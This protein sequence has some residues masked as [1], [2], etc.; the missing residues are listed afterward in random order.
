MVSAL[1]DNLGEVHVYTGAKD[2]VFSEGEPSLTFE[3]FEGQRKRLTWDRLLVAQAANRFMQLIEPPTSMAQRTH[4][5]MM[6]HA[7]VNLQIQTL[8]VPESHYWTVLDPPSQDLPRPFRVT[9]YSA[10]AGPAEPSRFTVEFMNT[11]MEDAALERSALEHLKDLGI[12]GREV[13][14]TFRAVERTPAG[15]PRPTI[16]NMDVIRSQGVVLDECLPPLT[17]FIGTG[18]DPSRLF[19]SE[20]FEAVWRSFLRSLGAGDE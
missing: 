2:M 12:V 14:P 7:F 5:E 4:V 17:T 18:A 15:F 9:N 1:V 11:N 6:P 16:E 8:C 19:Q 20:Q 3:T 13:Q 10:L